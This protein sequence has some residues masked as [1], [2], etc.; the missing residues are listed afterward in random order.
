M[1]FY[2][3]TSEDFAKVIDDKR[4]QDGCRIALQESFLSCLKRPLFMGDPAL[5]EKLKQSNP[6]DQW[7][8]IKDLSLPYLST[9]EHPSVSERTK[10]DYELR[11]YL[12]SKA[13]SKMDPEWWCYIHDCEVEAVFIIN[14]MC[15]I[16][17]PNET[18]YLFAG[19]HHFVIFNSKMYELLLKT[20][21]IEL[22]KM[23]K[24]FSRD[25][26]EPLIFDI[27][28]QCIDEDFEWIFNH[29]EFSKIIPSPHQGEGKTDI[30]DFYVK[31]YRY[32]GIEENAVKFR[33]L[34]ESL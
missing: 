19:L 31:A 7:E 27:I 23:K 32:A 17:Y 10:R 22:G 29:Y 33:E 6:D 16:L 26:N 34:Y 13:K 5:I 1:H 3:F 11:E 18:F 21:P 8:L 4:F 14:M 9:C 15:H 30:I 2:Q 20:D 12:L 25:M 24:S 28:S